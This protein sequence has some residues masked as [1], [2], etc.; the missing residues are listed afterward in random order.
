MNEA[1]SEAIGQISKSNPNYKVLAATSGAFSGAKILAS[2]KISRSGIYLLAYQLGVG[3]IGASTRGML[4]EFRLNNKTLANTT[5]RNYMTGQ[6]T[7]GA[8]ITMSCVWV[9]SL[10]SGQTVAVVGMAEQ[11]QMEVQRGS[12]TVLEIPQIVNVG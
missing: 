7:A 6:G 12:M 2:Y 4:T 10:T 8:M 5:M 1:V 9:G 11:D 3:S